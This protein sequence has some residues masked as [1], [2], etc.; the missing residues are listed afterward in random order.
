LAAEPGRRSDSGL[1]K[2]IGDYDAFLQ[3][4][5]GGM[6]RVFLAAPRDR[7]DSRDLVVVKQLRR[8]ITEDEHALALFMDESRIAMQLDHPNVV[9][10]R[11]VVS[12]PPEYAM[13]M[14]FLDGQSLLQVLNRI[15]AQAMPRDAHI[16]VIGQ[17]LAGLAHAHE[18]KD[19]SGRPLHIVHRDVSPSNVL[20]CYDGEAK[21]LDFGIAKATG[22]MAA[23]HEGVVRGKLGY[24]SPEQCLGKPVDARSDLYSVGVMLWEAVAGRRR[25]TGETRHSLLQARIEDSEPPLAIVA[26]DTPVQ[27]LAIVSRALAYVPEDRYS[28]ARELAADL[29]AYLAARP[30]KITPARIAALL[31]PHFEQERVELRRIVDAHFNAS[32]V[33][34]PSGTRPR[35]PTTR[36]P[37]A[38]AQPSGPPEF[39]RSANDED[40]DTSRIPVDDLLLMKSRR[41]SAAPPKRESG[42]PTARKSGAPASAAPSLPP[43]SVGLPRAGAPTA[44]VPSSRGESAPATRAIHETAPSSDRGGPPVDPGPRRS[45]W[46]MLLG[47][48][49]VSAGVAAAVASR[50]AGSG[51]GAQPQTVAMTAA[52]AAGGV[53]TAG[54]SS[55]APLPG[56]IHVRITVNPA[57]ATVRL[58]GRL[59]NANPFVGTFPKDGAEHELTA[60]ADDHV[61]ETRR[62]RFDENVDLELSLESNGAVRSRAR[63]GGYGSRVAL[64]APVAPV[65]RPPE[66][67]PAPANVEPGMDL[68][69]KPAA[70]SKHTIDEKDPYAQ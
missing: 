41:E 49:V 29:D 54:T 70:R 68:L 2:R 10:I 17:I 57:G 8:D 28:S 3:I 55:A 26:P 53:S 7:K 40:E 38:V 13:V 35:V 44:P 11:E 67:K 47:A 36:T 51:L 23:T 25:A 16:W 14:E 4:G 34:T 52:A 69:K 33:R 46:P 37:L 48:V 31:G 30:Q 27:L 6:A 18:L 19:S 1:P 45:A 12:R 42:G 66:A 64:P 20:V 32:K 22:A 43:P 21:L 59:L 15:G 9:R 39:A 24:A 60:S 58:D 5:A 56:D 50:M 63:T 62:I 65:V 61:R